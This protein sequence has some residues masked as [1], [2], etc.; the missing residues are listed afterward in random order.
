MYHMMK[1]EKNSIGW[2]T[3][4]WYA[5]GFLF[6]VFTLLFNYNNP[7][8]QFNSA[9]IFAIAFIGGLVILDIISARFEDNVHTEEDFPF[10]ME[11]PVG[12][13]SLGLLVGGFMGVLGISWI[14]ASMNPPQPFWGI[15][16]S[17]FVMLFVLFETKAIVIVIAIHGAFNSL[18]LA[19]QAGWIGN[20][21]IPLAST[22][23]N[24]IPI[25]GTT[26][27]NITPIFTQI[28][29]QFFLVATGEEILK[30]VAIAAF[31]IMLKSYYS[32]DTW[33]KW[34]GGGAAVTIWALMHYIVS[35]NSNG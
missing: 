22:G 8:A 16:F 10:W 17:G 25:I 5:I 21:L 12:W 30:V 9:L 26:I 33:F 34:I 29:F 20:S 4:A 35:L 23:I 7:Q 11:N 13:K 31:I 24:M 3:I 1:Y 2:I 15:F 32:E 19:V 27:P 28:G 6:I 14:A 18:V